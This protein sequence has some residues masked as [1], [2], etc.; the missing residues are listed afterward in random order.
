MLIVCFQYLLP[1][2]S[3]SQFIKAGI[4]HGISSNYM[5]QFGKE[6]HF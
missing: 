1:S 2:F 4:L 3:V 6:N 5:Y